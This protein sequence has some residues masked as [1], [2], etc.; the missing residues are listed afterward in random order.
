[1][2]EAVVIRFLMRQPF[3][4]FEMYLADGRVLR[5]PHP[6]TASFGEFGST[7][8]R[9]EESGKVE[10]VDAALVVSIRTLQPIDE[11]A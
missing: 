4:G 7:I 9:Y 8:V 2:T 3:I 5:V 11:V 1:M 10:T 6:E